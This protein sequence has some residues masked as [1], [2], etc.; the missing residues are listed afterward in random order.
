LQGADCRV[1]GGELALQAI[2]PETQ[3][4][5]LA[6]LMAPTQALEGIRI[7]TANEWRKH[8]KINGKC[9]FSGQLRAT[10]GP[11]PAGMKESRAWLNP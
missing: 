9:S 2:T 3:G 5:Q 8:G 7:A 6:L 11:D 10:A 4:L 1:D